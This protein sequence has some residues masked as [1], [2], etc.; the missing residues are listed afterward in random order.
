M[1]I[2][3]IFRQKI[4][5][6]ASGIDKIFRHDTFLRH[7]LPEAHLNRLSAIQNIIH[8]A[9]I[10]NLLQRQ[11]KQDGIGYRHLSLFQIIRKIAGG[12]V[13]IKGINISVAIAVSKPHLCDL[14][15]RIFPGT[16]L[17][18]ERKRSRIF[19]QIPVFRIQQADSHRI[20]FDFQHCRAVYRLLFSG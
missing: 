4:P 2:S 11:V 9:V 14:P 16:V 3:Q 7:C 13:Q 19:I 20:V 15:D 6:V 10:D 8:T 1:E 18:P 12:S 17:K 5:G